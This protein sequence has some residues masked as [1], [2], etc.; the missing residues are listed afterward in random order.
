MSPRM[1]FHSC[2]SRPY[3]VVLAGICALA[4]TA[5]AGA[6]FTGQ[7]GRAHFIGLAP[8][9]IATGTIRSLSPAQLSAQSPEDS[10]PHLHVSV[11][12]NDDSAGTA[13]APLRTLGKAARL[14]R[15]GTTIEVAPGIYTETI[16]GRGYGTARAPIRYL[17]QLRGAAVIRPVAANG[18]IWREVGDFVTIEGFRIDGTASPD[19]RVGILMGGSHVHVVGNEV[20]HIVLNGANDSNGGAGIVLSGGF[21]GKDDQHAVGNIVY[22]VGTATSDRVHGIYHQSTG[23][24]VNNLV[25]SN[26][27]STGIVLWHDARDITIANNTVCGNAIGI[28]VGA[29]DWYQGRRPADNVTV[30]NN[31]VC[32]NQGSGIQEHG[33]TG[34]GNLYRHN[35]VYRNGRDWRLKGPSRH[36]ETITADP[37]FV[38]YVRGGGADYHLRPDSPAIDKGTAASAPATDIEGSPRPYGPAP[39]IGAYE[40]HPATSD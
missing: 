30:V 28:N 1:T 27:G 39:D 10:A 18:T 9:G 29:G 19:A 36:V 33:F 14:A 12:G 7:T 11:F 40:W 17:S 37:Q 22:Q 34:N 6:S 16:Q 15:P 32:D 4:M 20:H 38:R 31:I 5:I 23:T 25:Y 35:L 24:I 21:Y 3:R 2:G 13:E 8:H 26:P